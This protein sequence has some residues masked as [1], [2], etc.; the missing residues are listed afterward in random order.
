MLLPV[1]KICNTV[2][3]FTTDYK[4]M[5]IAAFVIKEGEYIDVY[6]ELILIQMG[7]FR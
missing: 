1:Q 6:W 4:W 5:A 2:V 7:I 3:G